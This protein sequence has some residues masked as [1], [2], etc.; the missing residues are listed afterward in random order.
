MRLVTH[1]M[2]KC[3]IKGVGNGY[4]LIIQVENMEIVAMEYNPGY[5][6]F[7][8]FKPITHSYIILFILPKCNA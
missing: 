4:P 7:I 8:F 6:I 3:N 2:L 5:N 1:N